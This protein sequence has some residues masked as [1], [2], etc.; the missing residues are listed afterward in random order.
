MP[1]RA[2]CMRR[3]FALVMEPGTG[4]LGVPWR[5]SRLPCPLTLRQGRLRPSRS[6]PTGAR[7]RPIQTLCLKPSRSSLPPR[8]SRIQTT[9]KGFEVIRT[10][11]R[12]HCRL[13]EPGATGEIRLITKLFG[14][15]A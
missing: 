5:D 10:I 7:S 2:R 11:R 14:L 13:P 4:R 6:W 1:G 12:G 9:L 3:S 15:A 8:R